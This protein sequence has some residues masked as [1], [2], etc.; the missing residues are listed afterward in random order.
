[1]LRTIAVHHVRP[2][3]ADA[4][5]AFMHRVEA[6]VAGAPGLVSFTSHRDTMSGKLVALA[7]WSDP[8]AF[9]AAM[10]RIMGLSSERDPAWTEREDDLYAITPA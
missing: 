1:V 8:D 5:L 7:E 2:E 9:A 4:F 3:H 6:A 10:P